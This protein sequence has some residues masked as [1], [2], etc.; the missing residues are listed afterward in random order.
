MLFNKIYSRYLRLLAVYPLFLM[1]FISLT[2]IASIVASLLLHPLPDFSEPQAGFETRGTDISS[3]IIAW[4]NLIDSV[5]HLGPLTS[6]P[7]EW[8]RVTSLP[9]KRRKK[10]SKKKESVLRLRS[11]SS[12][13][14]SKKLLRRKR[15][16]E[17]SVL[18]RIWDHKD[19]G[20]LCGVGSDDTFIMVKSWNLHRD[21]EL[22]SRLRS[23]ISS[24]ML[25]IFVTSLTTSGAFLVSYVSNITS[26]KCFSL[27]A[28]IAIMCN[29][30]LMLSWT[31]ACLS[32]QYKYLSCTTKKS[33]IPKS[34]D[35]PK[36]RN[37]ISFIRKIK[38]W[39]QI[40]FEKILP[41][42]V[43]RPRFFWI[44]SFGTL[45]IVSLFIVLHSPGL[46]LPD[47]E[48]FRLFPRDHPFERYDSE[49]RSM[50]GFELAVS[51]E[52]NLK[53]PLT[54]VWGVKPKDNG[55][56]LDPGNKG[57]LELD[58]F[59][60]ITAPESQRWLLQFC[61]Q[62]RRQS[63]YSSPSRCEDGL[64]EENRY[65][66][67][68]KSKFPFE[69]SIFQKCL[70]QSIEN[71]YTTPTDFW[72]PSMA[73]PKFNITNHHVSAVI[74]E[75]DSDILF[76]FSHEEMKKFYDRVNSW[77]ENEI[78][79]YAPPEMKGGFFS[80][81]PRVFDVQKLIESGNAQTPLLALF[82]ALNVANIIFGTLALLVLLGW[83]LN[84]LESVAVTIT[85]GLSADFALHYG[86]SYVPPG[87]KS[88]IEI[89]VIQS[90][91]NMA[92]PVSMAALTTLCSGI[93]LIPTRVLPYIQIGTFI[94]VVMSVSW[95]YSTFFLQSLIRTYGTGSQLQC[96]RSQKNKFNMS[97]GGSQ[98]PIEPHH[99]NSIRPK[100][101]THVPVPPVVPRGDPCASILKVSLVK[102]EKEPVRNG[103]GNCNNIRKSKKNHVHLD[104]TSTLPSPR[105]SLKVKT[106]SQ[107]ADKDVTQSLTKLC[108]ALVHSEVIDRTADKSQAPSCPPPP[109]PPPK[110][111][112]TAKYKEE[113]ESKVEENPT[114]WK[115]ASHL[116]Y[117]CFFVND[118]GE[119]VSEKERRARLDNTGN[120]QSP[121][122]FTRMLLQ[123][124]R[125]VTDSAVSRSEI[126][127]AE[128][129]M[130]C[131]KMVIKGKMDSENP[132]ESDT[133]NPSES[134]PE[135][136][137]EA[138][139]E[140]EDE[141]QEGGSWNFFRRHPS[142]STI[143]FTD[144]SYDP[145][146]ILPNKT[147]DTPDIWIPRT[148]LKA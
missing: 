6:N 31:P 99:L 134:I 97:N 102:Y 54:F 24:S 56:Q 50:F 108:T 34:D 148:I 146:P 55:N 109:P 77:F 33:Q 60:D 44:L 1:I 64:T 36:D 129:M 88:D 73:G 130:S 119:I 38:D 117:F 9:R 17:D 132:R 83:K 85:V 76:S 95:T 101:S 53:L 45:G 79:P 124:H 114:T 42:F 89:R 131:Q 62:L 22:E 91:S 11:S 10:K 120:H 111:N 51:R 57:N 20:W 142:T 37:F 68:Q 4:D 47:K 87:A 69:K 141:E 121:K 139:Q 72:I 93:T 67:C 133:K 113:N 126:N 74:I 14:P 18:S 71:L 127:L 58:P 29:F 48:R 125:H 96:E 118:D 61:V 135:D 40:F 122:D 110:K 7:M 92:G 86:V 116:S 15:R 147:P 90:L 8:R 27:F 100:K 75:Y 25:S 30:F 23:S 13:S 80:E 137:E 123:R 43:I 19:I 143:L 106:Q 65:P 98:V 84:I 26:I 136:I 144:D 5:S 28:S 46:K 63:F 21:Q 32:F 82:C 140:E 49:F 104:G 112:K 94:I 3:R 103:Y 138:E 128:V 105:S 107:S 39:I 35:T 78:M 16:N 52:S 70:L 2:S 115:P 81:S 145:K 59:F 12:G 41:Y 66:C